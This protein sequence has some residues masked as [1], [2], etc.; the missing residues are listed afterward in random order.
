MK[1]IHVVFARNSEGHWIDSIWTA[2]RK[3]WERRYELNK[4]GL[5]VAIEEVEANKP[6]LVNPKAWVI[7]QG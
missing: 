5:H 2:K 7:S 1:K 4:K 6:V 3:A